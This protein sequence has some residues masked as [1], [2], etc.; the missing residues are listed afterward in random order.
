MLFRSNPSDLYDK[1]EENLIKK[2]QE[3]SAE[4]GEAPLAGLHA[5]D[6]NNNCRFRFDWPCAGLAAVARDF[7]P[8]DSLR[9]LIVLLGASPATKCLRMSF[10]IKKQRQ[11]DNPN[12]Q[13][14]GE[15]D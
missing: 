11:D 9:A 1:A 15:A 7:C 5:D 10:E 2:L 6:P 4:D 8:T 14:E 13:S 12:R 3:L